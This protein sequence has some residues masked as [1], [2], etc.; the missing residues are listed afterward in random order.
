M[1]NKFKG[2]SK[3]LQEFVKGFDGDNIVHFLI[4]ERGTQRIEI[5]DKSTGEI[6]ETLEALSLPDNLKD[7]DEISAML[8]G[9]F[10][11]EI[12]K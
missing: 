6:W 9:R 4:S 8:I 2:A 3:D 1:K 5:E 11:Q 12:K 7:F 10:L